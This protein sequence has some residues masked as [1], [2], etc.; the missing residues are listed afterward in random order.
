M[1]VCRYSSYGSAAC[2]DKHCDEGGAFKGDNEQA[3]HLEPRAGQ[4]ACEVLKVACGARNGLS[5]DT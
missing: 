2:K 5:V 3:S 4:L 1:L